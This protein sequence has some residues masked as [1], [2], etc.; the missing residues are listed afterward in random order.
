MIFNNLFTDL[1]ELS[2]AGWNV[3]TENKTTDNGHTQIRGVHASV[4]GSFDVDGGRGQF[5]A[6]DS[7]REAE[8]E[9]HDDNTSLHRR[10]AASNTAAHEQVVRQS[11]DG[12]HLTSTTSSS[13]ATSKI[14]QIASTTHEV[15]YSIDDC[16][17]PR[18]ETSNRNEF[19]KVTNT[20]AYEQSL[21]K[22][23][24]ENGELISRKVDYPDTN[25]K[26]IVET[27]CLP[28]G[29]RVTST[30]R[31]FRAPAQSTRSEHHSTRSE[32]KSYSGSSRH[33]SD[34]S[35]SSKVTHKYDNYDIVDSQRK[36]DDYDFKRNQD[37]HTKY[38]YSQTQQATQ[39]SESKRFDTR[40]S[41]SKTIQETIDSRNVDIATINK[42]NIKNIEQ[43]KTPTKKE[44]STT[45]QTIQYSDTGV[46]ET[47]QR[48]VITKNDIKINEKVHT[49]D[50]NIH[51]TGTKSEKIDRPVMTAE[52]NEYPQ[53][54]IEDMKY[55]GRRDAKQSIKDQKV[56]ESVKKQTSDQYQTTYQS[57]Y[58][59]KKIS[60]DW[61]PTHQAWAS[62]LRADS[63]STTR[64]IRES[65]PGSRTY[66]PST[67][68]QRSSM[69]PD[70]TCRKPSSR[71][72]SPSKIN[73]SPSRIL[74]DRFSTTSSNHTVS[75]TKTSR[76]TS[77]E[78][79]S[80]T[81]SS[82]NSTDRKLNDYCQR[83][84][85][86]PDNYPYEYRPSTSPDRKPCYKSGSPDE[87]LRYKSPSRTP[88]GTPRPSPSP[89]RK[90][91][92]SSPRMPSPYRS[93]ISPVEQISD[94]GTKFD[95]KSGSQ[96]DSQI[97]TSGYTPTRPNLSATRPSVS[98]DRKPGYM[99]PTVS[100]KAPKSPTSSSPDRKSPAKHT[101]PSQSPERKYHGKT[102]HTEDHYMLI[103]EETKMY[104]RSKD[105]TDFCRPE[106]P[107]LRPSIRKGS[108]SPSPPKGPVTFT[109]NQSTKNENIIT[110]ATDISTKCNTKIN[111]PKPSD[112]LVRDL[113]REPSPSKYGTYDKKRR[114]EETTSITQ[115]DKHDF[116]TRRQKTT[117]TGKD[118]PSLP[119]NKSPRN[120]LSPEKS[121]DSPRQSSPSKY[122]TYD[123]KHRTTEF[124]DVTVNKVMKDE[125]DSL[126][127]R[128]ASTRK[129]PEV[130]PSPTKKSHQ[131][132]VSPVKSPTKDPKYKYT[133]DFIATERT[134]EETNKTTKHNHPRQLITPST[135]PT[136]KH[137]DDEMA[138]ST[139][140]SS[141]TTSVSGF[142]YFSSPK[143][144]TT[145]GTDLDGEEY[146]LKS[147][148]S[149]E[150]NTITQTQR[151]DT[152]KIKRS[153]SPSKIPCRSPSP[154][155]KGAPI[156]ES[157]PR[158]SSLKKPSSG[159]NL[160]SPVEKPP[161]NFR[162]SPTDESQDFTEHKIIKKERPDKTVDTPAKTKYPFER[163]ETYEERCLKILG[164][165][166]DIT[167]TESK[168]IEGKRESPDKSPRYSPEPKE[169][170]IL[171]S[172]VTRKEAT[173]VNVADFIS[174][175]KS[176]IVTKSTLR[177]DRKSKTPSRDSS[178]TKLQDIISHSNSIL[179]DKTTDVETQDRK[180]ICKSPERDISSQKP[181]T[182]RRSQSPKKKLPENPKNS[183]PAGLSRSPDR[184]VDRDQLPKKN[185]PFR[186]SVS[187]DR[188]PSYMKSTT[189]SSTKFESSV[190][191][192][193]E[194]VSTKVTRT[195]L[196]RETGY[197]NTKDHL[198]PRSENRRS[199]SPS[200]NK[201]CT[202]PK[203]RSSPE[204]KYPAGESPEIKPV[205]KSPSRLSMSPDRKPGDVKL[206]ASRV[207]KFAE[208]Y[209][210][211][212]K[213]EDSTMKT[214]DKIH[215]HSVAIS[216]KETDHPGK[217]YDA[218][219][220]SRTPSP[221]KKTTKSVEDITQFIQSEREQEILDKVQ[222]SLRKL[223]P[224]RDQQSPSREKSPG[225]TKVSLEDIDVNCTITEKTS[226]VEQKKL[227]LTK[228]DEIT[229]HTTKVQADKPRDPRPIS[230]LATRTVSPVKKPITSSLTKPEKNPT[231]KS[232]E[233]P[234]IS[235]SISPKKPASPTSRSQSPQV[236][237]PCGIKP[238]DPTPTSFT[239]KVSS[240][241][242][243][244]TKTDKTT[245]DLK[246][247]TKQNSFTSIIKSTT[248]KNSLSHK[249]EPEPKHGPTLKGINK[250]N[251]SPKKEDVK[252]TRA[253]SDI[254][255]KTKK[256][257]PQR[258]KSKPEIQVNDVSSA[259]LSKSTITTTTN[260]TTTTK[261]STKEPQAK[262]APKPK[263]ATALNTSTDEDNI[264][265]DVEQ[266]K[267]SRENSPDRICPTPVNFI[268]DVGTP[269]FP[270]E[271]SEPDDEFRK[272]TYHTIHESESI[273]DDIVEICEDDELFV[274]YTDV[275]RITESDE[276]LL[277]VTDKVTKFT[278]KIESIPKSKE[279]T[280]QFKDVE[281]L[282]HSDFVDE[283]LKS[284]ECLLSVTEKVH[285]FAKGPR[286]T[287]DRSP[288]RKITDEYDT[289]TIYQDDYTKLS[290]NDK[291]HLFVETAET[292]KAPK[293]KPVQKIKRPNL[294]NVDESLKSDDCLL[295]VSAKVNKFVKSAEQFL[296]ESTES[297]E[298]DQKIRE[299]Y[300]KIMKHITN[301]EDTHTMKKNQ[302][303]TYDI[304]DNKIPEDKTPSFARETTSSHTKIKDYPS[305]NL[306][307][308]EKI[309]LVKLTTLRSSEAVKKAK[310]LFENIAS[311]QKTTDTKT[312]KLT[313]IGI[314]KSPKTDST[315]A[316]HPSAE[317]SPNVTDIDSE[318]DAPQAASN[319]E[320]PTNGSLNRLHQP[321]RFDEKLRGIP[322]RLSSQSPEIPRGK[323]PVHRTLE[324]KT[325]LSRSVGQ[326]EPPKHVHPDVIKQDY[327]ETEKTNV[328]S[329]QRPTKTSQV[330]EVNVVE[331]AEVS[332]RRG[333][334]KFGVE[335]RRTSVEKAT[336]S[337]ERRRSSTEHPCIEDIFDLDLL[338]QMVSRHRIWCMFIIVALSMIYYFFN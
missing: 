32:S 120:S 267:S 112:P 326:N 155:K 189:A 236:S 276:C 54:E 333:S 261:K 172:S 181:T 89:E 119:P 39:M 145:L 191:D 74:T 140:Q 55:T 110:T 154:E 268:E 194:S 118:S 169:D 190:T 224:N 58:T 228:N 286:D 256:T 187:P 167:K 7:H 139:G 146:H 206:T 23:E 283:K 223:S 18:R 43:N 273:V 28:D 262:L 299:E 147:Q 316:L 281:R 185:S 222:R 227:N 20:N 315:T 9:H 77:P 265:I 300:E 50:N 323:S 192:K 173:K 36:A 45:Q 56:D 156:K 200:K 175:E 103:D 332:S 87:Y 201:E 158:K 107:S 114:S 279:T 274:K 75:E 80:P 287:K 176:D 186:S 90:P 230:K 312:T 121:C 307:S 25:T 178:P 311:T 127:R 81:S 109:D 195:S 212:T 229:T 336:M 3:E 141:P 241:N 34:K 84:T 69:S 64:P 149:E 48:K 204:R 115:E 331:E 220:Y 198:S 249:T 160:Q 52:D 226:V 285:R 199:S 214:N 183:K 135:S 188:K 302:T 321:N 117:K 282:V 317:A 1:K 46:N 123:K 313:D 41:S 125:Y 202:F 16:D 284:D 184:N 93:T 242:M 15:P 37:D 289:E 294:S 21:R 174:H 33:T 151:P 213:S 266:A 131:E 295:S 99:R 177:E 153:P 82:R 113:S 143:T 244:P 47:S 150:T 193:Q 219:K 304:E 108:R 197:Q 270:D 303:E 12:A 207:T 44:F 53:R 49:A 30:R 255:I 168:D 70:K 305:P 71:G 231:S 215:Q 277:S 245:T 2:N 136:R 301:E 325:V 94:R 288:V 232:P 338:E 5:A 24:V 66:Q 73:H 38:D 124:E 138:P 51:I 14:Q 258:M 182:L 292:V 97:P 8:T 293:T 253:A 327:S 104:T 260:A 152:L 205:D 328:P 29:T 263:S 101:P 310:A 79:K 239:R 221:N 116:L 164:V 324:T 179:Y 240:G 78:R 306:K 337:A 271:V 85:Q 335:L 27:R 62:T 105:T 35:E 269:R 233:S 157:L 330:K 234:N 318:V 296:N 106:S 91:F 290:V 216:A 88:E 17:Q 291:A 142:I 171:T 170:S 133:T 22:S 59:Q 275:D 100:S 96:K 272:R 308:T 247:I 57:D 166:D 250:E 130:S 298:K 65:S 60:N 243:P 162:V 40:E 251:V 98:P 76:Y 264:I 19:T 67:T 129:T 309:P 26:I 134:T 132:S 320:R 165:V 68:F 6:V 95:K 252:V 10:E 211:E 161:S 11:D 218:P 209:S 163:R 13:S 92:S 31:E 148:K 128:R 159:S 126:T 72:G 329:Y 83:P 208:S 322:N 238:R 257:S 42:S 225:K 217:K 278:N 235:R 254:T 86:S 210:M 246:K 248:S 314:K 122:G 180:K 102:T 196:D 259:K 63:P 334:G 144:D 4:K 203:V 280:T 297:K 319:S 61:S 137:K 111:K 237:K